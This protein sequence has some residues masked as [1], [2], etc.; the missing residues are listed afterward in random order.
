MNIVLI[1][2]RGAG[3]TT[4]GKM[5]AS[6]LKKDFIEMDDLVAKKAGMKIAQIVKKHGWEYFRDL[7]TQ[8]TQE[9]SQKDNVIIATGGGVVL[10]SE[11]VQVLKKHG[12][13]FWL[14]V[15]VNSL[16]KRIGNDA[17]RPSLTGK[18]PK[19][20]MEETQIQRQ[21]LYEQAADVVI[22]TEKITAK[23]VMEEIITNLE[24]TYVY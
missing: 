8:I 5:L 21:K 20:D 13:L 9:V 23:E 19:E 15:G 7:E 18:S 4:V 2:M 11:N 17:N 10:R 3:K 22:D 1:G 16:L 6:H 12:K 14:S 24:D